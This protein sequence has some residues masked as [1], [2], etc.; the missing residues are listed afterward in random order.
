MAI[1]SQHPLYSEFLADWKLMRHSYRSERVIKEKGFTYL[2]AT[3]GQAADNVTTVGTKGWQNYDNYKGRARFPDFVSNAIEGMIGIMHH[4]PPV[5]ELP[6]ALE[7]LRE[8]ATVKG[9]PL[10]I[11]LRQINTEQLLTGRIGLLADVQDGAPAGVLPYIATYTPEH[12]INW[13]DGQRDELLVQNLNLTILDESEPVRQADFTWDEKK[14]HRVLI[15]GDPDQNES[16]GAYRAGTFTED[17]GE[18]SEAALIEPSIAGRR[19]DKIPFVFVNTRD[20]CADPD[21]PPLIG[22]AHL[23]L[24][25]YRGEADYRQNLHMQGQDTIVIIGSTLSNTGEEE[26]RAGAGAVINVVQGGDAKYIGVSSQGLPEQ[27]QALENDKQ[28]A[29][30]VGAKLIDTRGRAAESGDALRIRVSARTASL[31]QIALT[32]AEGLQ[33]ILRIMAEWVGAN[34]DEVKVEPNLDFADARLEGRTLV[35]YMTAKTLG[36][37]WSKKSIHR[38]MR[39]HDL[40]ELEFEEEMAELDAEAPDLTGTPEGGDEGDT[41]FTTNTTN[42]D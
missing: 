6:S 33:S 28:E 22:L 21:D 3:A 5:I 16:M 2:P 27:R 13:D 9:E 20:L 17:D 26:V 35:E 12:I 7:K 1:D 14:K 18:F 31:N 40:T 19:L 42:G 32:G 10:E 25:V 23:A 11:L 30:E 37:P 8:S 41:P 34:P 38:L 24:G 29:G 4:K 39:D 15:L 36:A